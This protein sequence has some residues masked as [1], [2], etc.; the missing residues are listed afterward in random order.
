M[1][2][3]TRIAA[4]RAGLERL[5]GLD[6][7]RR[8]RGRN[9]TKA[10]IWFYRD[11]KNRIALKDYLPRPFLVRQTLG[12][13]LIRR[14]AAAYRSAAGLAGLPRFLGRP[15]PFTLAV[16]WVEAE[17]LAGRSPET[18]P[19]G[20]FDRLERILSGLHERGVA[21]GDLHHRDVLVGEDGEVHLVDLATAWTLGR[22]PGPWRRALFRR[23]R[24]Q[25]RVALARLRARYTGGD[26]EAAIDSVGRR[27]ASWYRRGR[28]AKR[29]WDLIRRKHRG[30]RK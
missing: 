26:V 9:L 30:D 25:D 3:S 16:E 27:A 17:P 14:E 19:A 20:L 12:R 22:R 18:V 1:K 11:G 6:P 8:I 28:R 15:G 24:D 7:C 29:F 2:G 13:Y 4:S 10:D 23:F 21:L 5:R